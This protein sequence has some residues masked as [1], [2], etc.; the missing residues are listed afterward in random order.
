[1]WPAQVIRA[2][3]QMGRTNLFCMQATLA[4]LLSV[5][6]IEG[7]LRRFYSIKVWM[8]IVQDLGGNKKYIALK[9]L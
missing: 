5:S 3:Y 1:M 9:T 7:G 2:R 8:I 6:V 4:Q